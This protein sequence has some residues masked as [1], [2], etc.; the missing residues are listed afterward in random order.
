MCS[1]VRE[2][3]GLQ[4]FLTKERLFFQC[5]VVVLYKSNKVR[6]RRESGAQ[7]AFL[8]SALARLLPPLSK[9]QNPAR[10]PKIRL[11]CTLPLF[12]L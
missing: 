1:I 12:S 2:E 10:T 8:D 11:L 9:T 7:T 5:V 4:S 3:N 6:R